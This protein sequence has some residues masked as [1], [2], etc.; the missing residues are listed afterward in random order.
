ML[1]H[2]RGGCL[3][4]PRTSRVGSKT[5]IYHVL[6]RGINRQDIFIDD[7]DKSSYLD[8]LSRYKEECAFQVYAYCLMNNHVHLLIKENDIPISKIIKKL[9]VSYVNWYNWK[10]NRV[11]HLF[12]DRFKS[13]PVEDDRYLMTLLRYI[14]QNPTKVGQNIAEWTSY[15]DYITGRGITDSNFILKILS[16]SREA[17]L[18]QFKKHVSERIDEKCLD[19]ESIKRLSDKE[20]ELVIIKTSKLSNCQELN[21]L[22]KIHRDAIISKLKTEGLPI[23]QIERLTGINRGVI[24]KA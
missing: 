9:N 16:D 6:T 11:G 19:I 22:E 1:Y 24:L 13:E 18:V 20:A 2:Q 5:G 10:Y 14:H 15:N 7:E 12:Q 4:M 8:R 23:R 3:V 17:A 21:N